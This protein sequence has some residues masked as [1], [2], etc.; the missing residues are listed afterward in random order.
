MKRVVAIHKK[1]DDA[2]LA[3]EYIEGRE[4]YVGVLG[5]RD[6]IAF[7]PI[8][9]D[10]SGLPDGAPR[11][12]D[13]KAKWAKN[14]AE[15][16]G[17]QVGRGR[18]PRRAPR[19]APEG[20]ARRLPRP[21]RPRLRPGRPPADR[22]G[23]DLRDRGQRQLLPGAVSEFATAAAADERALRALKAAVAGGSPAHA[24]LFF[25]PER[26]GHRA[27]RRLAQALNCTGAEPPC[28]K[29]EQC[30]RIERGIHADVQTVK[31]EA[32][33]GPAR[34]AISIE[35]LRDVQQATSLNP[36]EGRTRVVIID[37]ADDM[38][39]AAQNAFL[40]TL[41][42]PP[43]H[44][45]FILIAGDFDKLAETILS[46]CARIDFGLVGS[47]EIEAALVARGVAPDKA[48]LLARLSSSSPG[49]A[50]EA[51]TD[52]KALERRADVLQ[53]ARILAQSPL[54]DRIDLAEKLSDAFERDREAVLDQLDASAAWW[55]DV[56]LVRTGAGDR[57]AN[58]DL[59]RE[60]QEDA[61]S[62]TTAAIAAFLQAI[63]E[64]RTYLTE[65]VQ[66]R[67]ALD[68]LMLAAPG[69]R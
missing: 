48:K 25:G 4:F 28:G 21:P 67:I 30:V 26:V 61:K 15:Y 5:N 54:A 19:P 49:W 3:E 40:K 51:A 13:S 17:T 7:P 62:H 8:E 66:S 12:L 16:K 58:L 9:M 20:R 23:R 63:I 33:D 2:A 11:V 69:S 39:E 59:Q 32:G 68:A 10:F 45:A 43:P 27:A 1:F 6:P 41:E 56:L 22:D 31:M 53:A 46:R 14:S 34:K 60:L 52:A 64:T 24:Y 35:Q 65:N 44:V 36:Y 29:C 42:E 38:S 47:A 37:P 57:I 50:I 55:R 18:R